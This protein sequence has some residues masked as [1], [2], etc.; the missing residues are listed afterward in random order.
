MKI[1]KVLNEFRK[2]HREM[3][4]GSL[5]E[6]NLEFDIES[7]IVKDVIKELNQK[8]NDDLET[9]N[10]LLEDIHIDHNLYSFLRTQDVL[11]EGMS[12]I[13]KMDSDK[14]KRELILDSNAKEIL[15]KF[16]FVIKNVNG[17]EAYCL[18]PKTIALQYQVLYYDYDFLLNYINDLIDV[19]V[20]HGFA[21]IIELKK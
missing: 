2:E 10:M 21:E 13:T 7:E 14:P 8:L 3:Y 17:V 9:E 12:F 4:F 19:L 20:T 11:E 6:L 18:T 16:R 15:T 5:D 1:L